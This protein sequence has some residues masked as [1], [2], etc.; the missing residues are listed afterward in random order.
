MRRF[1]LLMVLLLATFLAAGWLQS[2]PSSAQE[3]TAKKETADKEPVKRL[4]PYFKEIVT[5]EQ[6]TK[7]YALQEEYNE[8]ISVLA[9][10]IKKLQAARTAAIEA[11]LSPEQKQKLA[12]ARAAASKSKENAAAIKANAEV[13][14][15]KP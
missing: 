8:K 6:K 1:N 5:E 10:E 4:P 14:Q 9:E 11:L 3:N 7:I 15:P 2:S 13:T 12:D